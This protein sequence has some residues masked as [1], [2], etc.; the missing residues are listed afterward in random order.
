MNSV[1]NM[2]SQTPVS[3]SLSPEFYEFYKTSVHALADTW[4]M[5]AV[6]QHAPSAD[7]KPTPVFE[8]APSDAFIYDK[9]ANTLTIIQKDEGKTTEFSYDIATGNV[10]ET[11]FN[12]TIVYSKMNTFNVGR[13]VKT[14]TFRD[15]VIK[16]IN[17]ASID[18]YLSVDF[19]NN[20]ITVSR[21]SNAT[22]AA[23]PYTPRE[24]PKVCDYITTKVAVK[25]LKNK[26]QTSPT[27]SA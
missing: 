12:E 19:V 6:K 17:E 9:D 21:K 27:S 5:D 3:A 18:A 22:R 23:S 4:V 7:Q 10:S 8:W 13:A 24:L 25:L 20:V 11:I 2:E 14:K 15:H 16:K 1:I 26:I